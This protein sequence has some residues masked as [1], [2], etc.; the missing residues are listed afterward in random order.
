MEF[1]CQVLA[2][3]EVPNPPEAA[4]YA[5]GTLVAVA[6][7]DL[8]SELVGIV[9]DTILYNPDFGSAGP[10]IRPQIES[11]RLTPDRYADTATLVGI[12]ALGMLG[13]DKSA[14]HGVA[15]TSPYIGASVRVLQEDDVKAF[16]LPDARF[17]VGY[18]PH[19]L[20]H[21]HPLVGELLLSLSDSLS[22]LFPD[23]SVALSVIRNNLAWHLK[24]QQA[25]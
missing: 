22:A 8:D 10:R 13:R 21:S 20:A 19:L 12:I 6:M 16:H 18:V 14:L 1:V 15:S 2:P 5:F 3:G 17:R 24:V 9:F 11:D 23:E 7:A 4:Q 25:R